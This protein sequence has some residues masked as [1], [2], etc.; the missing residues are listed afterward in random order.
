MCVFKVEAFDEV[1]RAFVHVDY[2]KRDEPEHKVD[3]NLLHNRANVMEPHD[4]L[5][6]SNSGSA[7]GK[8]L[9]Q[10]HREH[11]DTIH[12]EHESSEHRSDIPDMV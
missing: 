10:P 3:Y 2:L 8:S 5:T 7:H 9:L 4:S 12:A 11:S 6:H 1:E